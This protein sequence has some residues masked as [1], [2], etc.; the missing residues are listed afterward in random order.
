MTYDII[1][2]ISYYM[3]VYAIL[4]YIS[5]SVGEI[6]LW[7]FYNTMYDDDPCWYNTVLFYFSSYIVKNVVVSVLLCF[8][9]SFVMLVTKSESNISRIHA[10]LL[11]RLDLG[12]RLVRAIDG[13]YLVV[14]GKKLMINATWKCTV[15]PSIYGFSHYLGRTK[16]LGFAGIPIADQNLHFQLANY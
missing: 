15:F 12:G 4:F 9:C 7:W 13:H 6:L 8:Y 11:W 2:A 10:L 16:M 1:L 5:H 3:I 14:W